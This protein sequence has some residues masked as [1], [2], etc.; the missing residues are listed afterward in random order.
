M[1]DDACNHALD[2]ELLHTYR[3]GGRRRALDGLHEANVA[4]WLGVSVEE[5]RGI[6]ATIDRRMQGVRE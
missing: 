2:G 1:Q 4:R 3:R 5:L 6:Y